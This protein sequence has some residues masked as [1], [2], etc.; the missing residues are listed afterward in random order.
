MRK[1]PALLIAA[2]SLQNGNALLQ[3][4][5]TRVHRAL[6]LPSHRAVGAPRMRAAGSSESFYP[7]NHDQLNV[8][9]SGRLKRQR[10]QQQ[11][12]PEL[13]ID[14]A[15]KAI[16]AVASSA[17]LVSAL[18]ESAEAAS[19]VADVSARGLDY[20][21]NKYLRSMYTS[22]S[23][24]TDYEFRATK[25]GMYAFM[26]PLSVVIATGAQLAGIGGAALFTPVFILC[27]PLLGPQYPLQSAASAI[28]CALLTEAFSFTS[29]LI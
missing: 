14:V 8:G 28:A 26:L 18:P 3:T 24:Y 16:A 12:S 19:F 10:T 9:S 7:F 6:N 20:A 17:A 5:A 25:S 13:Q 1:A 15:S 22:G 23:L 4:G 27:F 21:C 2:A 29:G 11:R